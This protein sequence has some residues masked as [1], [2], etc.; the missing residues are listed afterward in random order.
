M[1]ESAAMATN[2]TERTEKQKAHDARMAARDARKATRRAVHDDYE[3]DVMAALDDAEQ[4]HGDENVKRVDI[5]PGACSV[6]VARTPA[7]GPPVRHLRA[8]QRSGSAKPAAKM[9]AAENV[10]KAAVVW[11]PPGSPGD[12]ASTDKAYP[13][14]TETIANAALALAGAQDAE[15]AGK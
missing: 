10:C 9:Q 3:I 2:I 13:A 7:L 15:D 5:S 8:L 14:A 1:I 12:Y 4:E 6:I 11:P